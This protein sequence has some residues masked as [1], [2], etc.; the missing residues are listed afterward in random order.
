MNFYQSKFKISIDDFVTFEE[1]TCIWEFYPQTEC[2]P[3]ELSLVSVDGM[4]KE[5]CPPDL[6]K[7]ADSEY[8]EKLEEPEYDG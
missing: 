2:E 8:P 5:V 1:H 3:A 7:A 4:G 6:W